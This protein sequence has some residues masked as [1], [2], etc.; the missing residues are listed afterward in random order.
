MN[1]MNKTYINEHYLKVI[2]KQYCKRTW[3]CLFKINF[4]LFSLI[5]Y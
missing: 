3:H 4:Y 1:K 5:S 2:V